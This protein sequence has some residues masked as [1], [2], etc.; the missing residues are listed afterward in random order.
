MVT[1]D[2]PVVSDAAFAEAFAALF[3]VAQGGVERPATAAD[4]LELITAPRYVLKRGNAYLGEGSG[5]KLRQ[6]DALVLEH[7]DDAREAR[8]IGLREYGVV[9]RIVR[10]RRRGTRGIEGYRLRQGLDVQHLD[11]VL[12]FS[13]GR[14]EAM[15]MLATLTGAVKRSGEA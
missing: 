11:G 12:R 5:W 14:P 2:A 7:L 9:T 15:E 1:P 10:I 3:E 13:V 4:I 8:A 6:R